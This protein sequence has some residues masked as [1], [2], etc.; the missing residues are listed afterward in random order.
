MPAGSCV[1]HAEP[2]IPA[3]HPHVANG[4]DHSWRHKIA[5]PVSSHRLSDSVD[6]CRAGNSDVPASG[7]QRFARLS[8]EGP[9]CGV[10]S[11]VPRNGQGCRV[12][13]LSLLRLQHQV[14]HLQACGNIGTE[15]HADPLVFIE[16]RH[17]L[18]FRWLGPSQHT[19]GIGSNGPGLSGKTFRIH[20]L[21]VIHRY[22]KFIAPAR[23]KHVPGRGEGIGRGDERAGACHGNKLR[24][25]RYSGAR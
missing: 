20:D 23:L 4:N 10:V 16:K 25:P 13:G 19:H 2:A 6:Q 5:P 7:G 11:G 12:N 8:G 1:R 17:L 24:L 22:R 21:P 15:F 9:R 3:T 14:R 18:H